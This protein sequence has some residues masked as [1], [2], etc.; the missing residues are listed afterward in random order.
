MVV[1]YASRPT[2]AAGSDKCGAIERY[3]PMDSLITAAARALAAGDPLGALNRVALRDDP[4]ALALRGTAMAQL[5][6][7]ARA[8]ELLGRAARAFGAHEA[9]ASA[10]CVVAAAEVAL[11]SRDLAW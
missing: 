8:R 4:P 5:G 3:A 6:D 9:L 11:A 10:R 1:G 2:R 7:L